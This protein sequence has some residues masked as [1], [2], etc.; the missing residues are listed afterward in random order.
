MKPI[1]SYFFHDCFQVNLISFLD[2]P[3]A[4]PWTPS[5]F[6][7]YLMVVKDHF[8]T[9][10]YSHPLTDRTAKQVAFELYHLFSFIGYPLILQTDNGTEFISKKIVGMLKTFNCLCFTI[11]GRARVPRDQGSVKRENQT[12]KDI[13]SSMVMERKTQGDHSAS[14]LKVYPQAMKSCNST[15]KRGLLQETAYE[16]EIE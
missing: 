6:Y 11:H 14:W 2:D 7:H 15:K 16:T 8:S 5:V 12:I 10:S 9:L 1:S 13:I 4:F 3:Q